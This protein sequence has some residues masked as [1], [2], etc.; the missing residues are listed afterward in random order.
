MIPKTIHYCWFGKNPKP[1][2]AL[3]C[4][5]SWKSK[6]PDYKIIEWNE[7]NFNISECPLYVR[8]AYEMKRWA[9]VTDYVRLKLVYDY[10]G[11]YL[12]TDVELLKSLNSLLS[13]QAFFGFENN[14]SIATGLG[15]GAEKGCAVVKGM[16]DDYLEIPFLLPDGNCDT[17]PC[18]Q[19]NTHVLVAQGLQQNGKTQMLD[20]NIKILSKEYLCP[21]D[22]FTGSLLRTRKTISIHWFSAS[23]KTTEQ[24]KEHADQVKR[25]RRKS[26][27]DRLIHAPNR[28]LL[29]ALG[30]EEYN[31]IK[32]LLRHK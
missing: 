24:Q 25:L 7:D 2:L 14:T 11:I 17:T 15:F 12:D 5:K 3:K 22:Y 31:T 29:F 20:P 27:V 30:Q 19:R 18:P 8:Q 6:C 16:M 28:M 13:Y 4:I 9:F 26:L 32:H 10:G 21:M 23:W 1:D